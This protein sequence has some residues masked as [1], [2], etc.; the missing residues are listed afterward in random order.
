MKQATGNRESGMSEGMAPGFIV[1]CCL[2][3][4]WRVRE[5]TQRQGRVVGNMKYGASNSELRMSEGMAPGFI[6]V[7]CLF[8]I[9][10]AGCGEDGQVRVVGNMKYGASN[11]ELRMSEG[12][13]SLP[14]LLIAC[15]QMLAG[16]WQ[17]IELNQRDA[18][19]RI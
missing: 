3:H 6:V 12:G 16:Y 13:A 9:W 19:D 10:R 7:C 1:A 14:E 2:F 4:I 17:P 11:S 18:P 8:H 5:V 15:S